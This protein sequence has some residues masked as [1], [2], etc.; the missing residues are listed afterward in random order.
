MSRFAAEAAG[1]ALRTYRYRPDP[2]YRIRGEWVARRDGTRSVR[3]R[4][5]FG[6]CTIG[7]LAPSFRRETVMEELQDMI[8]AGGVGAMADLPDPRKPW[9]GGALPA[10]AAAPQIAGDRKP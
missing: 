10:A 4:A 5:Y 1:G 9:E 6:H 8:D 3:Y 7:E 2:R